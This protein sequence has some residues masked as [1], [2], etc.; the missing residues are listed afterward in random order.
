MHVNHVGGSDGFVERPGGKGPG[1]VL[2]GLYRPDQRHP[3]ARRLELPPHAQLIA[4]PRHRQHPDVHP[5]PL[6]RGGKAGHRD[7][8]T[9]LGV[10]PGHDVEDVHSLGVL[11]SIAGMTDDAPHACTTLVFAPRRLR[12]TPRV[13]TSN[14]GVIGTICQSYA[15]WCVATMTQS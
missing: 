8:P 6:L 15:A 3:H 10:D 11:S 4:G 7:R 2:A 5:R 12:V 14:F 9:R 1:L 13:S